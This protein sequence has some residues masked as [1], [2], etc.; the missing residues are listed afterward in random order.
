MLS[1][2]QMS[3]EAKLGNQNFNRI[4]VAVSILAWIRFVLWSFKDP[5]YYDRKQGT[6]IPKAPIAVTLLLR[7]R[8]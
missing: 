4:K 2:V 6:T 1:R 8:D 7:Y 5:L 3:Q